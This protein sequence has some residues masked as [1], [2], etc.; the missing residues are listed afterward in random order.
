MRFDLVVRQL[1]LQ[2]PDEHLA[3]LGLGALDIDLLAVDSVV[4]G[5]EDFIDTFG[6]FENYKGEASRSEKIDLENIIIII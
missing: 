1:G 4:S 2:A 6:L 3:G 5:V